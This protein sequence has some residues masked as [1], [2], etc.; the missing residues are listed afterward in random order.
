MIHVKKITLLLLLSFRLGL[1][2]AAFVLASLSR[3]SSEAPPAVGVLCV[4]NYAALLRWCFLLWRGF[5]AMLS[6]PRLSWG[7]VLVGVGVE[8]LCGVYQNYSIVGWSSS[9]RGYLRPLE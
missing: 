3:C 1:L 5:R 2:V 7:V 6:L 9:S 4:F 8:L